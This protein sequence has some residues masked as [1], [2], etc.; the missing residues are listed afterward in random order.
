MNYDKTFPVKKSSS[1]AQASHQEL[2]LDQ[3][4]RNAAAF[5]TAPEITN[6]EALNLLVKLAGAGP[7]DT[8]LDVACGPG[9]VVCAFAEITRHATG[10][11]ATPAM[12]DRARELQHEKRLRNVSW[13][14]ADVPPLPYS[15]AAFSIVTSRYAFHHLQNPAAV[16]SEMQRVCA[17][18]GKIVLADVLASP[19]PK[20]AAAF[21][22]MERLRDPSHVRAMSLAEQKRLLRQ[23]GLQVLQTAFYGLEFELGK[24]LQGSAPNPRNAARV[25]GMFL[26]E[27]D[28]NLIDLS[29]RRDGSEIFVSYPIAVLVAQKQRPK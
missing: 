7:A 28:K 9:L 6:A 20:K 15:D 14:I 18:R 12:I 11:D 29:V 25:R 23:A 27:L 2:I 8:V 13:Q 10:I 24:L 26:A 4:T 1:Q 16:I 17:P 3:F 5:A 19:D 21:N 22:R